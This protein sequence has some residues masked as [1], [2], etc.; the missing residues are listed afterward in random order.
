M[1]TFFI[2]KIEAEAPYSQTGNRQKGCSSDAETPILPFAKSR[3]PLLDAVVFMHKSCFPDIKKKKKNTLT[4]CFV[5]LFVSASGFEYR[6]DWIE[7]FGHGERMLP[8][9]TQTQPK[10]HELN[11]PPPL[12][13]SLFL[14]IA[15]NSNVKVITLTTRRFQ[16]IYL[17]VL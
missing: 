6:I 4:T 7:F 13:L 3:L 10:Q 8:T 5:C 2:E 14:L 17:R 16:C 9:H 12:S 15:S 1:H 11:H